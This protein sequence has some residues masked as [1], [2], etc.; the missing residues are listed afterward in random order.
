MPIP[1]WGFL[2]AAFIALD[3]GSVEVAFLEVFYPNGKRVEME[4]GG[5]FSHTAIRV[6]SMWLHAHPHRGV[7]LVESLADYGHTI[8]I[9]VN[10]AIPEPSPAEVASWLGKP[11]DRSYQWGDPSK[12]YC[13]RLIADLLGICANPSTFAG[14][15]WKTKEI[16]PTA[17]LGLSPDD[18]FASLLERDFHPTI[19]CELLLDDNEKAE[20]EDDSG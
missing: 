17:T 19:T 11:F 3:V 2:F 13:S 12:T 6:G 9:L 20:A 1:F 10:P 5:R 14:A 15:H 18:L 8:T 4:P 16:L 7:Q